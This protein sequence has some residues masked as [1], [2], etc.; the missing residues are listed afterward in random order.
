[1]PP[2][3]GAKLKANFSNPLVSKLKKCSVSGES[4]ECKKGEKEKSVSGERGECR[5]GEKPK[6]KSV[7]KASGDGGVEVSAGGDGDVRRCMTKEKLNALRRHLGDGRG[8]CIV[9][10]L[11]L[12]CYCCAGVNRCKLCKGRC[13]Q[14]VNDVVNVLVEYG[15]IDQDAEVKIKSCWLFE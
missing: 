15:E 3:G 9:V 12:V 11:V 6:D 10:V 14:L 4:S 8:E 7:G 1:M 13:C 2:K 5:K